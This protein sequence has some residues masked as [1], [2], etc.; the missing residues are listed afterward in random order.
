M[1]TYTKERLQADGLEPTLQL[2]LSGVTQGRRVPYGRVA[3]LL[4]RELG[5]PKVFS[6][7][8]GGVAGALMERIWA[9]DDS[10]P[11]INLL[12][13]NAGNW[14]PGRGS[15]EFLREWFEI[16]DAELQRHR[17]DYVQ[18]AINEVRSFK[19]WR[20]VYRQ[21]F[22][23]DYVP[24]PSIA[25]DEEFDRDG[26]PDNPRYGRGGEESEEHKALKAHVR[27]NPACVGIRKPVESARNEARL[28]SGDEMDVEFLVGPSR[29]GIEVK[30]IR[31]GDADLE[32]GIYQ[33]VKYLAVMIAESGFTEDQADCRSILVT[34]RPLPVA[35]Q[36]LAR[37]LGVKHTVVSVNVGTGAR[38]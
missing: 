31:S 25:P 29:I 30:S 20:Q 9:V 18:E 8:I 35:L 15:D 24:D 16:G 14:E 34:E 5:I 2:L 17:K 12:V 22:G 3:S 1:A 19:R 13:V 28:L 21:L 27:D 10:V 11:P 36:S 32:R 38:R 7:H 6:T 37:R 33:C 23:R 4:E 26:Q